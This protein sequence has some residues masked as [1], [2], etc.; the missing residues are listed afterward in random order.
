MNPATGAKTAGGE[1]NGGATRSFIPPF[2]GD[3]V[4]YLR[5]K[6]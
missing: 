4:L 6:K 5:G 2:S 1:V 3:A